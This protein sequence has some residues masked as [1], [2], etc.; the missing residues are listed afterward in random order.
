MIV[1]WWSFQVID[2]MVATFVLKWV[3]KFLAKVGIID[4]RKS[5]RMSSLHLVCLLKAR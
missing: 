3:D 5:K 2:W 4:I 1:T